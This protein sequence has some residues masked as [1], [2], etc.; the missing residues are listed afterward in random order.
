MVSSYYL[1][2]YYDGRRCTCHTCKNFLCQRDTAPCVDCL[3]GLEKSGDFFCHCASEYDENPEFASET[4]KVHELKILPQYFSPM[5]NFELRKNDRGF[6]VGDIV[7]LREWKSGG[8][9]T[10]RYRPK[11]IQYILENVEEYGLADGYCI[12]GL[13]ESSP[14]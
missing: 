3:P 13:S 12:L 5:K 10:G 2:F 4:T 14:L 6:A 1:S 7:V 9:Y 11:F 8:G